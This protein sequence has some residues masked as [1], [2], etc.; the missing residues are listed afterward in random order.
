MNSGHILTFLILG[1]V[2]IAI[3]V[4]AATPLMTKII[5]LIRNM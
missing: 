4:M 1:Y 2:S 3:T 5:K